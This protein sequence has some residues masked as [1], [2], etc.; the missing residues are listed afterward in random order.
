M[1]GRPDTATFRIAMMPKEA[2]VP[3]AAATLRTASAR[4]LD[5]R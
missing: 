4:T 2:A 3:S 5:L 1:R